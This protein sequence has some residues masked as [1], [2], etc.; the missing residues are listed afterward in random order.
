[1]GKYGIGQIISLL[2]VITYKRI[3]FLPT[4][5]NFNQSISSVTIFSFEFNE[6]KAIVM[7]R[8]KSLPSAHN[9]DFKESQKANNSFF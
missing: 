1:M 4:A 5:F 2:I 8:G 7:M 6:N 3:F 9:I